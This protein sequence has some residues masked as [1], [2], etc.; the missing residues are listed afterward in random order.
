MWGRVKR[1][2]GGSVSKTELNNL[3][4]GYRTILG[5]LEKERD[6]QREYISTALR[7]KLAA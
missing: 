4:A 3:I 7:P 5:G 6:T 1:N 2:I